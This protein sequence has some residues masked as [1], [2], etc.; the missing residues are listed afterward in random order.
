MIVQTRD[1]FEELIRVLQGSHRIAI[2]TETY[3][4]DNWSKR[5]LMGI[6]F[7]SPVGG[8][9]AFYLPVGHPIAEIF[10]PYHHNIPVEWW[11]ELSRFLKDPEKEW[12]WHNAAFDLNIIFEQFGMEVTNIWDTMIMAHLCNENRFSYELDR[13]GADLLG[14]KKLNLSK[15]EKALDKVREVRD[16]SESGSEDINGWEMIPIGMM[17]EYAERDCE[18]TYKLFERFLP[19]LTQQKV[20][21]VWEE[22][23]SYIRTLAK[24]VRHGVLYDQKLAQFLEA[25]AIDRIQEIKRELGCEGT[26]AQVAQILH[27]RL[28]VPI[29]YRTPKT[30]KPMTDEPSL[31]R[32]VSDFP[33]VKDFV[34]QILEMRGLQ[35]EV[36]T[37][38]SGANKF[39]DDNG[40]IHP[41]LLQHGTVSGRLS[42]KK[43][44]MQNLP[45]KGP[46][47]G[48]FIAPEGY[49]LWEFDYKQIEF[50]LCLCYAGC[51]ILM[52]AVLN[53]EDM[54][55]M[56]GDLIGAIDLL[57]PEIGRQIG[58]TCNF[59][60]IYGG[61]AAKLQTTLWRDVQMDV[62][63]EQCQTWHKLFHTAYPE[64]KQLE[65]NVE[66]K[67]RRQGY[68]SCWNGRKQRLDAD[69]AY[70]G[71]NR[72]IQGGASQIIMR[73]MN[74]I[75]ENPEI[76][77]K[78]VSQVHDSIWVEMPTS[79]VDIEKQLIIE[80]MSDW[81]TREF[82]FPFDVDCGVVGQK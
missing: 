37:W 31:L 57:G 15:A 35:R 70:M 7:Y 39:I 67:M 14:L 11:L 4:S 46:L 79:R 2:D 21:S 52:D 80:A 68:I 58:K 33:H 78:M 75:A 61:G 38:Y 72:L 48:L 59:L 30:S 10:K 60:L 76:T 34:G 42:C 53:G 73:S 20:E 55:T 62:S 19:I 18:L 5:K 23:R 77:S 17:G 36:S 8:G 12:I 81:P 26:P 41:G 50:R 22:S 1:D 43:P 64:F 27:E 3:K 44:N 16:K 13:L 74:L 40:R 65:H 29:L 32:Y 49:E 24:T 63:I 47:K 69:H 25:S 51:A 66:Q 54:H 9:R 6:A 71:L 28:A 82:E 56:T 45:R